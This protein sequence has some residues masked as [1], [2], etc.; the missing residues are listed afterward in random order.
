M[1]TEAP[2]PGRVCDVDADP[3]AA[4]DAAADAVADGQ[5]IVLPTDTVY[6]VGADAFSAAAVQRLLD[7]KR[8][9]RDMPPPVLVAEVGMVRSLAAKVDDRVLALAEAFWPGPLTLVLTSPESLRMDLGDRGQT[10]AVRVPDHDFTRELLRRTGPLAVSSANVSGRDAALTISDAVEQLGDSVAVYLDAGT[11]SGPVP[12]T[13]LDLSGDTPQLLRA[14][15]LSVAE[16]NAVVP[17]LLEEPVEPTVPEESQEEPAEPAASEGAG[18]SALSDSAEPAS[19]VSDE[20][21]EPAASEI[22]GEPTE[23]AQPD[24][25]DG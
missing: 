4:Y 24:A 3:E 1:S 8:R 16:I 17:G 22:S 5:V 11:M 10:I 18:E 14:G 19:E 23:P 15:R 6:G 21:S 13:I 12:S 9:G 25:T 2:E 20:P 7:A